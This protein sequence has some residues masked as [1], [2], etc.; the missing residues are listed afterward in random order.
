MFPNYSAHNCDPWALGRFGERFD[1]GCS[2]ATSREC[3]TTDSS[4]KIPTG[5]P[6]LHAVKRIEGVVWWD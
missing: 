1:L 4:K 2:A 5:D 6:S 3:D